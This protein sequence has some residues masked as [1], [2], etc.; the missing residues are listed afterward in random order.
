MSYPICALRFFSVSSESNEN[1]TGFLMALTGLI[2]FLDVI[3]T[4]A[5]LVALRKARPVLGLDGG[6]G[7]MFADD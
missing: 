4:G 2:T 6:G 5:G 1:S 7:E 3:D